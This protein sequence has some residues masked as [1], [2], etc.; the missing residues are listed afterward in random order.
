M[1]VVNLIW[2][3]CEE[4]EDTWVMTLVEFTCIFCNHWIVF[5]TFVLS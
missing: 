3:F 5:V 2:M 4:S 1:L